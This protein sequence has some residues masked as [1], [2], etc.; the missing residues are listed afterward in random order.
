[1]G[2]IEMLLSADVYHVVTFPHKYSGS[3]FHTKSAFGSEIKK[4]YPGGQPSYVKK[5][6][7]YSVG[8]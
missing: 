1:M 8:N 2:S 4:G 5:L 7:I 6:V 3:R